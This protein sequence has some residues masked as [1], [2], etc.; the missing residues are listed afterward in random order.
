MFDTEKLARAAEVQRCHAMIKMSIFA[1]DDAASLRRF[2]VTQRK[3]ADGEH[4]G[5]LQRFQAAV[6]LLREIDPRLSLYVADDTLCLM[7]G[8]PHDADARPLRDNVIASEGALRISRGC[9]V[10]KLAKTVDG[11]HVHAHNMGH[12]YPGRLHSRIA[13]ARVRGPAGRTGRPHS[14]WTGR[15]CREG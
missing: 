12:V 5:S 11:L 13:L 4:A 3:T 6:D 14:R 10:S 2:Q 9:L 15:C 8:P 7:S 1:A